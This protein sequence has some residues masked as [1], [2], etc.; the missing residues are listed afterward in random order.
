MDEAALQGWIGREEVAEDEASLVLLRRLAALLDQDPGTIRHGAPMPEGWH[1]ALF[2]PLARQS[3]L[4]PDGHAA[5]GEFLPPVPLPRRM[6]AGR[7]TWFQAPV[8]IGADVRRVSRITA[9]APKTGRSGRMIFVTVRHGIESGGRECVA[10]EQDLVYREAATPGAAVAEAAPPVLP[11][12][13]VREGFTPDTTLLF[14]YSAVTYNGHRIHYDADYARETEG[15]PALVVNGGITT[16]KLTELAKRH[17]PGPL[18]RVTTR[19][20]RPLFVGRQAT[21]ACHLE[22]PGRAR[23]WALDDAGRQAFECVAES[24]A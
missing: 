2:G 14:R 10:E 7:R 8:A 18:R 4:G 11:D 12:G 20:G 19:A 16:T 15:Y 17:L 5:L 9:I 21:L 22:A 23:L 13:T 1:A 24:A 6:F 3:G